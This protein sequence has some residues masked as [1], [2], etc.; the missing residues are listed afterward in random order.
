[1]LGIYLVPASLPAPLP[2]RDTPQ[3]ISVCPN[4][5]NTNILPD[6][7]GGRFVA[8][9]AFSP[10]AGALSALHGLFS[11]SMKGGDYVSN[12]RVVLLE[13]PGFVPGLLALS[14]AVH[15]KARMVSINVLSM[16]V[17]GL[18]KFFYGA[19]VTDPSPEANDKAL[20]RALY[21]WSKA[22]VKDFLE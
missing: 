14:K 19:T 3:V 16:V 20:Q 10:S 5:V 18:Q 2:L 4:W 11:S 17:L 9:Q 22:A 21:L 15:V 12:S 8:S 6:D 7:V 1:M 13:I